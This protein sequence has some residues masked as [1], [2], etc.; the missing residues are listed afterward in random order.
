MR[1]GD[2]REV[3]ESVSLQGP[4]ITATLNITLDGLG[5][6]RH[7]FRGTVDDKEIRGSVK[8]TPANQATTTVPWRARRTNRSDYFA[9]TGTSLFR[10]ADHMRQ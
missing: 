7:E 10:P 3:L 9:Q 6:T 2:R 4:E 8:L 1:A 5:L